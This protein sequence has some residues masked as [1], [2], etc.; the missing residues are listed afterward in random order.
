MTEKNQAKPDK[1]EQKNMPHPG[2]EPK[3]QA[4]Y[5]YL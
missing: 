1:K 3:K 2:N 5:N 4:G